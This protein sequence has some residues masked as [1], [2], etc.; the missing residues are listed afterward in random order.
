MSTRFL[1]PSVQHGQPLVYQ[2]PG[3]WPGPYLLSELSHLPGEPTPPVLMDLSMIVHNLHDDSLP[4][5]ELTVLAMTTFR[6]LR[7]AALEELVVANA[8]RIAGWLDEVHETY[9]YDDYRTLMEYVAAAGKEA[10]MIEAVAKH[11]GEGAEKSA[12]SSLDWIQKKGREEERSKALESAR[13]LLLRQLE[14]R[15]GKV[16]ARAR[17][18]VRAAT[19]SQLECWALRVVT[20][21]SLAEVLGKR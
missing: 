21:A 9:G 1:A 7:L 14:L 2:G 13:A 10:G 20:A 12:M 16:P 6:L 18:K 19:P 11:A 5:S 17:A 3:D 8:A 15:F 4:P